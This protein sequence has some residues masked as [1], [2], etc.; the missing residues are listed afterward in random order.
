MLGG[1]QAWEHRYA[2]GL[3]DEVVEAAAILDAAH[4]DDPQASALGA[5]L[6][7]GLFKRDDAMGDAVQLQVARIGTAVV[8]HQDGAV[9]G[10]EILLQG[11]DLPAIAQ[12]VLRQQAHF[13]KAVEHHTGRAQA[14]DA[15]HDALDR[16][17][18]FDLGR[19]Q[20][21]LLA[22]G[23][24]PFLIDQ[25]EQFDA[26]KIPVVAAGDLGQFRRSLRQ[27]DVKTAFAQTRAFQQILQG[28]GRLAAAGR[29]FEQV[30]AI[31]RQTAAQDAVEFSDPR[32]YAR[33]GG[34]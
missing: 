34:R 17:A 8:K 33:R 27:G 16:L 19:L 25:L 2:A 21:R 26:V 3:D 14:I 5:V 32:G 12:R 22:V 15:F 6:L 4:L 13:R 23:V 9:T 20:D 18:Q 24:Q 1:D 29:A 7:R 31:A 11:Q 28:D 10:R 30:G